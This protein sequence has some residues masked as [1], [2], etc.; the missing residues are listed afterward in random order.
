MKLALGTAQFGLDYGIANKEGQ[1]SSSE[2]KKILQTAKNSGINMLDTAAMYGTS[3]RALGQ[4]GVEEFEIVTKLPPVP[5]HANS[6]SGWVEE[7]IAQSLKNLGA[8]TVYAVLLH[9]PLQLMDS[10]GEE[11]YAALQNLRARGWFQKFG[12]S[13]Y[14][15]SEL[16]LILPH[17]RVDLIQAPLNLIDRRL[18][19]S[20]W[21]QHLSDNGIEVHARSAFLQGAL[22]MQPKERP[23]YFK[24]WSD[25][26]DH[27]DQWLKTEKL[28]PL[29]ACLGF[30][31][32]S[33]VDRVIV[34]VDSSAQ[35]EAIVK[36]IPDD[37]L[38]PPKELESSEPNLI[39]PGNWNL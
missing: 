18:I 23:Q 24:P 31:Y 2:A 27:Y 4:A 32:H 19:S 26:F 17:F 30:A 9:R 14:E 16:E 28:S 11:L 38:T 3:E 8:S 12:L 10:G 34:G 39:N 7:T 13:V 15:P 1:I 5:L 20:G 37:P 21:L 35:L 33:P 6:I 36:A 29:E 22:L 25:S